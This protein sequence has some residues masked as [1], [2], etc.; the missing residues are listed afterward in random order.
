MHAFTHEP[1][2]KLAYFI[3][4]EHNERSLP[5]LPGFDF[6]VLVFTYYNEKRE[7]TAVDVQYDQLSFFLHCVGLAQLHAWF[8][9]MVVTPVAVIWAKMYLRT[10]LVNPL[11]FLMQLVLVPVLLMHFCGFL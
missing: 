3:L 5:F 1:E 10:G 9:E 8:M 2:R 11:T 7:V 4:E 6:Y